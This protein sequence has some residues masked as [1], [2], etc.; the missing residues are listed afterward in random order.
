MDRKTSAAQTVAYRFLPDY[1]LAGFTEKNSR[2]D[3]IWVLD[4]R[5]GTQD[6]TSPREAAREPGIYP[7][8]SGSGDAD[9][10]ARVINRIAETQTLP[11]GGDFSLLMDFIAAMLLNL[12]APRKMVDRFADDLAGKILELAADSRESY[13]AFF[14]K[15]EEDSGVG[16]PTFE[17]AA[18]V[19]QSDKHATPEDQHISIRSR[20]NPAR[21]ALTHIENRAWGVIV[22]DSPDHLFITSDQ[23]TAL[24]SR[25]KSGYYG[26]NLRSPDTVIYLPLNGRVVLVGG[27]GEPPGT[28][29]VKGVREVAR[30]NSLVVSGRGRFII[31]PRENF[32]YMNSLKRLSFKDELII[33][34][35]TRTAVPG[36]KD[37]GVPS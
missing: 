21:L 26:P 12:P 30:L 23:P 5:L 35:L 11:A 14:S 19:L 24:V 6:S 18:D 27:P 28:S 8:V 25:N 36:L 16:V 13:Q 15:L 10:T 20:L 32:V 2:E 34:K 1:Y 37:G 4:R 9:R 22:N 3:R 7:P 33:K 29:R 31:S 17:E